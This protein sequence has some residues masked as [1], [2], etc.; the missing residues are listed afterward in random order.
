M[1]ELKEDS[2]LVTVIILPPS[3]GRFLDYCCIRVYVNT[4]NNRIVIRP[5]LVGY[6]NFTCAFLNNGDEVIPSL[7]Y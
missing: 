6:Y 2:P 4:N 1:A 5:P 7:E 3:M